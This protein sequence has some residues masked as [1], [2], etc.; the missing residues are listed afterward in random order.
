MNYAANLKRK[1]SHRYIGDFE[2]EGESCTRYNE[3]GNPSGFVKQ[4]ELRTPY[5]PWRES[6]PEIN[7]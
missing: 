5:V 4:G 1:I 3:L 6:R 2:L 7:L